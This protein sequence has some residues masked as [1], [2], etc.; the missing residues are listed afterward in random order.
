MFMYKKFSE[1]HTPV[2]RDL[3]IEPENIGA[4]ADKQGFGCLYF[5]ISE[6]GVT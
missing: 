1:N 6:E 4:V 3:E 5:T 2:I